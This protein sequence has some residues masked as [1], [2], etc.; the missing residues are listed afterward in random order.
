MVSPDGQII[1]SDGR[2]LGTYF[3]NYINEF[4]QNQGGRVYSE[5]GE[6]NG[7]EIRIE[8]N[9][10]TWIAGVKYSVMSSEAI[11]YFVVSIL[12]LISIC[13]SIVILL[14]KTATINISFVS[15][16]LMEI[17]NG[18]FMNIEKKIPV[19]SNDEIGDLVV[20][21]N[22]IREHEFEIDK[23][24]TE[25][26]AN[27]SHEFKTPINVMLAT[28]QLNEL[29]LKKGLDTSL[30]KSNKNMKIIRQNCF[31]LLRLVNNLIDITK[32]EAGFIQLHLQPINI[33][34]FVETITLSV[35][36]YARAKSIKIEFETG[37]PKKVIYCDPEKIERIMLNL[38]SNAIKFTN[39]HG[40]ILVKIYEKEEKI[41]ISVKDSGIGIP[42]DKQWMIFERFSQVEQSLIRNNEGS[43]IGLSLVKSFVEMHKGKIDVRSTVGIG[44]EFIVELPNNILLEEAYK[45]NQNEIGSAINLESINIELSDI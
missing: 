21:F 42:K 13:V 2:S 20:A 7:A 6:Y 22:K 19:T 35:A 27:L 29:Y 8:R 9:G 26:F 37:I 40:I 41:F 18:E 16:K 17:A 38:L 10:G 28:I 44:S 45:H 32:I 34:D 31:R 43:G 30:E 39:P 12:I 3:I 14:A 25:F 5:N 1:T 23:L 15:I 4:S 11:L 36:E 33:L 24:K